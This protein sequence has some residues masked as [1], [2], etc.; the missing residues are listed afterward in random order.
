M[1]EVRIEE[2][3]GSDRSRSKGYERAVVVEAA[4]K[5]TT[6]TTLRR[7]GGSASKTYLTGPT[8]LE[9]SGKATSQ[10]LKHATAQ[11]SELYSSLGNREKT[12]WIAECCSFGC[13]P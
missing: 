3:F 6:K 8:L 13:S 9:M 11:N 7:E 5:E 2:M 1:V 12:R 10:A 4:S